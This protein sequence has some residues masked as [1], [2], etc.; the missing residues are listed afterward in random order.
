[1]AIFKTKVEIP[2]WGLK[3]KIVYSQPI[4]LPPI[5]YDSNNYIATLASY[6]MTHSLHSTPY[7]RVLAPVEVSADLG[8]R[9]PA[10]TTIMAK[11]PAK[12][13]L[14]SGPLSPE[15]VYVIP[16]EVKGVYSSMALFNSVRLLEILG[17]TLTKMTDLIQSLLLISEYLS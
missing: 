12:W 2:I 1:M 11:C 9:S 15:H 7:I 5:S 10:I 4:F 3:F 6:C 14:E 13:W 17:L 16:L 8:K